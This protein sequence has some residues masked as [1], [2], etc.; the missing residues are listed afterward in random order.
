MRQTFRRFIRT[1]TILGQI[2]GRHQAVEFLLDHRMIRT[3]IGP[4]HYGIGTL[5]MQVE[6]PFR[7]YNLFVYVYI[8]S[9][10]R[11]AR[12]DERFCEALQTLEYKMTNG[13][14]VVE[15]VVPKMAKLA[16]CKKGAGSI[17]ATRRYHEILKN[18]G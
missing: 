2:F 18:L 11:R 5:F 17:V 7:N 13:Q 1:D 15:R 14:I 12:E 6:Y 16:F 9:F 3:P 4:C 10:Y 8:L